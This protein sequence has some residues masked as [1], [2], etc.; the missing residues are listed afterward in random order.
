MNHLPPV[1]QFISIATRLECTIRQSYKAGEKL[2][3]AKLMPSP[4]HEVIVGLFQQTIFPWL[5]AQA[6]I[7]IFDITPMQATLF[8]NEEGSRNEADATWRPVTRTGLNNVAR[9]R[10]GSRIL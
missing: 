5:F 10:N 9:S 6:D 8:V 1:S 4:H 3:I 2:G 7:S